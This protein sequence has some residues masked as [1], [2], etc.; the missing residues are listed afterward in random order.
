MRFPTT[1]HSE[2]ECQ[3][4]DV[5]SDV[6]ACSRDSRKRMDV[7][8]RYRAQLDHL[9]GGV[10]GEVEH[11]L[12][13]SEIPPSPAEPG[14]VDLDNL[15]YCHLHSRTYTGKYFAFLLSHSV[16]SNRT[17]SSVGY[18]TNPLREVCLRNQR[19]SCEGDATWLLDIVLG[20]FLCMEIARDCGFSWV[21]GTRGKTP[22][23]HKAPYL[24]SVYNGD[25]YSFSCPSARP[26]TE[27]LERFAD[28]HF[29][30][31]LPPGE[32]NKGSMEID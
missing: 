29:L 2:R 11:S 26:L 15:E 20:P 10:C 32:V 6:P 30:T 9:E 5:T 18:A 21:T 12:S 31:L 7:T 17:D 22:K 1:L 24:S 19:H 3:L 4:K 14:M 25:I 13:Y 8:S 23:R 16:S 28:P 27:L